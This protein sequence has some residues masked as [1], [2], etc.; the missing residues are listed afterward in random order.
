MKNAGIS[1]RFMGFIIDGPALATTNEDRLRLSFDGKDA[2]YV[3]ACVFSPRVGENIGVGMV[4]TAPIDQGQTV[5]IHMADGPRS[6][7]IVPLPFL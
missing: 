3:S 4:S 5:T 1:R 7:R 2:G 6:A